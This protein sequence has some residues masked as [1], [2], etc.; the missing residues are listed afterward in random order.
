MLIKS[1]ICG[2]VYAE[3]GPGWSILISNAI[4]L[5]DNYVVSDAFSKTKKEYDEMGIKFEYNQIK[6]KFGGLRIYCSFSDEYINGVID[7][8]EKMSFHICEL[9]GSCG[10]LC[11][12][13]G[14]YK[15][16]SKDY[17]TSNE[18]NPVIRD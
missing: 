15:T 8:A 3:C 9:T 1:K 16:L 13:G 18:W 7:M 11:R 5:I 4:N 2:E 14:N 10:F 12:K 6:E 17:A